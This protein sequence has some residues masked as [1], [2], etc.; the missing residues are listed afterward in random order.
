M[1]KLSTRQVKQGS[2]HNESGQYLLIGMS[3]I[4][5]QDNLNKNER[6]V[7]RTLDTTKSGFDSYHTT[8]V[9]VKL[10]PVSSNQ[11]NR[12]FG[13]ALCYRILNKAFKSIN[14]KYKLLQ[15]IS[16]EECRERKC[17]NVDGKY[18]T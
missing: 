5:L 1:L 16:I 17:E 15:V 2:L 12:V 9:Y 7:I 18:D 8:L 13:V 3:A 10:S 4:R 14:Q 6:H 11:N